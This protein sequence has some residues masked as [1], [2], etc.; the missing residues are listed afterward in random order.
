MINSRIAL[1]SAATVL[2]V[3]PNL[4]AIDELLEPSCRS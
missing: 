4:M 1:L 2:F 3:T